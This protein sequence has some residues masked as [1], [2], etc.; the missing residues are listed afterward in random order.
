[1]KRSHLVAVA[2]AAVAAVSLAVASGIV[3]A[4]DHQHMQ[5]QM[6]PQ[7]GGQ[8]HMPGMSED[9]RQLVTLPAPMQQHMLANMRD[10]LATLNEA[11]G[12][13]GAGKFEDASKLLEARLGMSSLPLHQAT[14][15]APYFPQ[16]MQDA[17]TS[18]HRAASR[19]AVALQDAS[20]ARTF[21]SMQQVDAD[22]HEV[23]SAC[24]ACHSGYRI[25]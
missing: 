15:M 5:M 8:M 22:L 12:D 23:T 1:M 21:E 18:M 19:L 2:V 3:R 7:D 13:I 9:T 4:Q 25:R 6:A 17:G 16:P 20:V 14:E 11:V 10:H 24:V